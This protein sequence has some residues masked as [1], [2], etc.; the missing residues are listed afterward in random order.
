MKAIRTLLISLFFTATTFSAF[1]GLSEYNPEMPVGLQYQLKIGPL[2]SP[3]A[4]SIQTL[5]ATLQH[6][7]D[8]NGH[9]VYYAGS[10]DTYREA[11]V[12]ENTLKHHGYHSTAV[13][14]WFSKHTIPVEDGI[15]FENDQNHIDKAY[16]HN[17][18]T[19]VPVEDLNALLALQQDPTQFY[20]SVQV[21]VFASLS[22]KTETLTLPDV[23]I[24]QNAQGYYTVSTGRISSLESA[25]ELRAEL[26]AQGYT[27]CFITAWAYGE[28]VSTFEAMH[29][30]NELEKISLVAR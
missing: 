2:P 24:R 29:I 14:A 4:K 19:T 11:S 1:A 20:Y 3:M 22:G 27:D 8:A 17:A 12:Y 23:T 16:I 7:T 5:F 28:R 25:A 9:T 6:E 21:G 15:A 30:E 13:I 26:A 10:F 18:Q